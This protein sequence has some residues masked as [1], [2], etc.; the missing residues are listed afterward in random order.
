M[1]PIALAHKYNLI[2][3]YYIHHASLTPSIDLLQHLQRLPSQDR[4]ALM[5]ALAW[6]G[7]PVRRL[8]FLSLLIA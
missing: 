7:Y 8:R 3:S 2:A 4:L 1:F 6:Q 5:L